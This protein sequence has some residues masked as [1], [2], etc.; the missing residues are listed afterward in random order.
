MFLL[1]KKNHFLSLWWK[2]KTSY[3]ILSLLHH[4][5]WI[6]KRFSIWKLEIP[7]NGNAMRWGF[8]WGTRDA[9]KHIGTRPKKVTLILC[10]FIYFPFIFSEFILSQWRLVICRWSPYMSFTMIIRIGFSVFLTINIL[11]ID[12]K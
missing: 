1:N 2:V 11:Q 12:F 9:A 4:Y 10:K 6:L 5:F 3:I 7:F 8:Y